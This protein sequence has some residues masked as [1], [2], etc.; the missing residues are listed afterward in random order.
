MDPRD[1]TLD[2]LAAQLKLT[3]AGRGKLERA[4]RAQ[5]E[6]VELDERKA[7]ALGQRREA[8]VGLRQLGVTKYRIAQVLGVSQTTAAAIVKEPAEDSGADTPP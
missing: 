8:V 4:L 7:R 3:K 6:I 2:E 5:H 1:A